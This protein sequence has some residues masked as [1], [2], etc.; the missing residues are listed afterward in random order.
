ML[1]A[2]ALALQALLGAVL[3]SQAAAAPD[4]F[5]ICYATDGSAPADHGQ[6]GKIAA[7]DACVLCTLGQGSHAILGAD[8][9][10]APLAF[11]FSTIRMS[12]TIERTASYESPTGQ[13]QTGPP[14][15]AFAG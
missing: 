3:T 11:A 8:Q 7:H 2:Y 14:R 10:A 12:R 1:A 15:G 5:V 13:Y 4:P 9:T 6:P